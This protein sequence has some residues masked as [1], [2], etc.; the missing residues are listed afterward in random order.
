MYH[1]P[2]KRKQ[3]IQRVVT[4]TLMCVSIVA[5][6]IILVFFMLGYQ[7]N[8]KDGKIEQGGLVQLDSHP[9]GAD[10][11]IDG[12]SFGTQT[13]AKTTLNAGQHYVTMQRSGYRAW[14][15]SVNVVAGSVLWLDYARLIPTDL[16]P[17]QVADFPTVTSTAVS[18]NSKFMAIKDEAATPTIRLADISQDSVKT[19]TL[20]LPA[21]SYTQPDPDKSQSFSFEKWDASSRYL[22]VKHTYNDTKTEWIDVDTQNISSTK[23]ITTLLGVDATKLLFSDGSGLVLYAQVGTDVRKIDLTAT[24]LSGPLIS[25]VAEFSLY[26]NT[27]LYVTGVNETT[28]VRT[29]GYYDL[30]AAKART[31]RSYGDN[32]TAPLHVAVAKYFDDTYVAIAYGET[33]EVMKG[34]LPSSDT[35]TTSKLDAVT[36]MTI[37]GGAQYLSILTNGRFIVAQ[38]AGSYVVYDLELKKLTTTVIKSDK[39][40]TKELSWIDGYMVWSD[41]NNMVRLYEFDGANQHDIMPVATGFSVTLS[42]NAKYLYGIVS[43][44]DGKFHLE[45]V[46]MI[47]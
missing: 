45:R 15:K 35:T 21:A 23:N 39:P 29:V 8:R 40:L 30:S 41:Q 34:D 3:L 36:T 26:N 27:I 4:Y 14:Q 46:Q 44:S 18:P 17:K 42:A 16:S 13:T 7:F 6:V 11:T 33:V 47:L 5:L 38:T 20:Q 43:S 19:T 28:K 10:V 31:I 22:L 9:N 25:N 32:G 2:S 24:T 37:P 12:K 1:P